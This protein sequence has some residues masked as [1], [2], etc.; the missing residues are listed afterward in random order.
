MVEV[1]NRQRKVTLDLPRWEAFTATA[2]QRLAC[3]RVGRN[4]CFRLGSDDAPAE[5]ALARQGGNH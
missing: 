2:L 5:P 1:V 3:K 4:R